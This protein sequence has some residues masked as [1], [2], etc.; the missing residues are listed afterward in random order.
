MA[1]TEPFK[2][3]SK[4]V[5]SVT[6]GEVRYGTSDR[7]DISWVTMASECARGAKLGGCLCCCVSVGV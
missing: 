4:G 3:R 7:V 2:G 6:G 1:V 5:L